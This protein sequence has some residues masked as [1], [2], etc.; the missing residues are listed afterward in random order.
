MFSKIKKNN[1]ITLVALIV[2]IIVLLILAGISIAQLTG[3]GL[4]SKAQKATSEY[5]KQTATEQMN[6]KITNI[7]IASYIEKKEMPSLQELADGLCEDNEIEYVLS[8]SKKTG[9]LDKIDVGEATS[10]FTK[11]KKYPFE[12]E[13]DSSLRL[14]SINGVKLATTDTQIQSEIEK[15]KTK[16]SELSDSIDVIK[17]KNANDSTAMQNVTLSDTTYIQIIPSS[18]NYFYYYIKNGMCYVYYNITVVNTSNNWQLFT[19]EN[20]VPKSQ[21]WLQF[22]QHAQNSANNIVLGVSNDGILRI[23]PYGTGTYT[24][25]FSYPIQ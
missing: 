22:T 14:A 23:F 24:G 15:L 10:I 6:L 13:I 5:D 9:S 12:F 4:F 21:C 17:E 7:Q 25:F 16:V 1:G 2:T 20:A 3:N 11:L 8:E 19:Q 18:Y